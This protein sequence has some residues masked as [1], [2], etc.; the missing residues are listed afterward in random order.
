MQ[1]RQ[2][3]GALEG[4]G[5]CAIGQLQ[6]RTQE[7]VGRQGLQPRRMIGQR[8]FIAFSGDRS[9]GQ[10]EIQR[11]LTTALHDAVSSLRLGRDPVGPHF[12]AQE[13]EGRGR[14][15]LTEHDRRAAELLH[16]VETTSTGDH[17][18]PARRHRQQRQDLIDRTGIVQQEHH[19]AIRQHP[20]QEAGSVIHRQALVARGR[21]PDSQQQPGEHRQRGQ[22]FQVRVE[23]AKIQ[24][25][26]DCRSPE[27]LV[28]AVDDVECQLGL[29]SSGST[30]DHHQR[31]RRTPQDRSQFAVSSDQRRSR[32]PQRQ[33]FDRAGHGDVFLDPAEGDPVG[34]PPLFLRARR[35][36]E[37]GDQ[38]EEQGC[39][40]PSPT[41]AK[42]VVDSDFAGASA[43]SILPIT[44]VSDGLSEAGER[45]CA[46]PVA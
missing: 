6:C 40:E 24:G 43:G 29:P 38:I 33:V 22:R 44:Q 9:P 4:L 3:Q 19:R 17:D 39:V 45:G 31:S 21:Y 18:A 46:R 27:H 42:A 34:P 1:G 15:Q 2:P 41:G 8:P 25:H 7:F 36:T 13:F 30:G 16:T 28:P 10:R 14:G 11:D 12:P 5:Q 23:A 37:H 26:S 20:N 35:H 32:R